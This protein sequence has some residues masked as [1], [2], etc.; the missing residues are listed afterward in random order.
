ME[1]TNVPIPNLSKYIL[2]F[3]RVHIEAKGLICYPAISG[4]IS[5]YKGVWIERSKDGLFNI[6]GLCIDHPSHV[7]EGVGVSM[8][9]AYAL[10]GDTL[11]R[12]PSPDDC[13][14]EDQARHDYHLKAVVILDQLLA[15]SKIDRQGQIIQVMS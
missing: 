8:G 13:T 2:Q 4:S 10:E 11:R 15:D 9:Y 5:Y 3:D 14:C 1:P 7:V 12:T 6:C